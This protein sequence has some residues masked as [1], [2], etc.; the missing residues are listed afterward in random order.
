MGRFRGNGN[1]SDRKSLGREQCRSCQNINV[2][3]LDEVC[4]S[5]IGRFA[6]KKSCVRAC[7]PSVIWETCFSF[8]T[9][10]KASVTKS[11]WLCAKVM[12][13]SNWSFNIPPRATPRHLNFC[14]IFVQI[15]PSPGWKA[16]Q[17][18][19]PNVPSGEERGL[20]SLTAAGNGS[21]KITVYIV[22][23]I[24]IHLHI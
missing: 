13:Q 10:V 22:K 8:C 16:V 7:Y 15:P 5:D 19:H 1:F 4:S 18:P 3:Q 9:T 2:K 21:Y 11:F 23:T 17:M 20:V 12:Y 14:K 24:S 6:V